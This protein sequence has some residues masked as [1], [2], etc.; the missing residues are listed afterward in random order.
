MLF[1]C[2]ALPNPPRV[3]I[4]EDER[5]IAMSTSVNLKRMGCEVIAMVPS[6]AEAV[7][8]AEQ[9]KPDLV[10]MDIM[11]EGN[12]DGIQAAEHIREAV[13]GVSIAFC[14]AYT[15]ASTRARADITKP[16]AFLSKPVDFSV[17]KSLLDDL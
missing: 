10:L 4:V 17:L 7:L 9:N 5:I 3:L 1:S 15:D 8:S 12:M 6:G 11:L 13:P 16:L 2:S 14:T